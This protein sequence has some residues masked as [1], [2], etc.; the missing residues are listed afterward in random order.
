MRFAF[1]FLGL[2]VIVITILLIN[3]NLVVRD[4]DSFDFD[5]TLTRAFCSGRTCQDFLV[6]CSG[7]EVVGLVPISG[8]VTFGEEWVDLREDRELC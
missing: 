6:T 5:R 1:L 4:L 2:S 3:N 7:S 8:F